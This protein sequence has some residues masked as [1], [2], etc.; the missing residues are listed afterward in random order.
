MHAP[1]EEHMEAKLQILK[2]LKGLPGKGLLFSR[3]E[4]RSI[5]GS[6]DADW[7]GSMDDRST[8]GYCTFVWGNL[9]TWRTKKQTVVTCSSSKA[10]FRV[11]AHGICEMPWLKLLLEE[12]KMKINLL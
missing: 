12:L 5:E 6:I 4:S 7:A 9:V 3:N 2:Y 10:E 8:S 11:V 1:C